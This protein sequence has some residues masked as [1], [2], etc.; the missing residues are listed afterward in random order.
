MPGARL[1]NITNL[2][3]GEVST[4]RKSDTVIV[5]GGANDI[6]KNEAH[7][8]LK[9]LGKF[10]KKNRQN[11]NIMIVTAPHRHDLQE[12]SFVNKEIEVFNRKLHKVVKTP[13]TI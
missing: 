3:G 8:G 7:I 4:L 12:T 6:N 10:A 1:K 11:T 2:A 9:H 5:I 13:Q